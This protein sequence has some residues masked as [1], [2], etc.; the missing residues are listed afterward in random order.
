MGFGFELPAL[1]R[2]VNAGCE[3]QQLLRLRLAS[4]LVTR[5]QL[6]VKADPHLVDA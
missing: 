4:H 5:S 3:G 6:L 1:L 2:A